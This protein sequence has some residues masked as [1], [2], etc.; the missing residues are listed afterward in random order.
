[1]FNENIEIRFQSAV[2]HL[3][4]RVLMPLLR[5]QSK[6]ISVAKSAKLLKSATEKRDPKKHLSLSVATGST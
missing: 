3:C 6:S 2:F 5:A 1:M 4:Q